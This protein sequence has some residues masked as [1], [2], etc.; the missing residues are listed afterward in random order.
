MQ[1]WVFPSH[2]YNPVAS[3]CSWVKHQ[4][5]YLIG[6][7]VV[8]L[9]SPG[10]FHP[11][12]PWLSHSSHVWFLKC[13]ILLW[14]MGLFKLSSL[15]KMFSLDA[16]HLWAPTH[17]LRAS[18]ALLP[19]GFSALPDKAK[20]SS[21]MFSEPFWISLSSWLLQ[22][23]SNTNLRVYLIKWMYQLDSNLHKG[24]TVLS[25]ASDK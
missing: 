7:C 22:F 1:T 16:L 25:M 12:S 4:N 9:H 19:Q 24:R 18:H 17:L 14:D 10:P 6:S 5:Q 15:A 21:Y 3:L 13:I 20:P 11:K 23:W 8:T 2:A